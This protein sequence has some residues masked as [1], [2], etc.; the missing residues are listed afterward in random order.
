MALS[1]PFFEPILAFL[2]ERIGRAV[3]KGAEFP[4]QAR[5]WAGIDKELA[6]APTSGVG[7]AV[8][9]SGDDAV[10]L[11]GASTGLRGDV[12]IVCLLDGCCWM[13]LGWIGGR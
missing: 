8:R 1:S 11:R 2:F 5:A 9:L 10:D 7:A 4:P 6:Q 12:A 13:L 3:L